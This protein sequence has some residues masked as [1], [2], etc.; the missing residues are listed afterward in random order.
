[1]TAVL[2]TNYLTPNALRET[3]PYIESFLGANPKRGIIY[4][5]KEDPVIGIVSESGVKI[6]ASMKRFLQSTPREGEKSQSK[7]N[8]E[9]SSKKE[10]KSEKSEKEEK[11]KQQQ[12]RLAAEKASANKKVR[13][14]GS[15]A[16]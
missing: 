15:C 4:P 13:E 11:E 10:K 7:W 16:V 6:D 3:I 14:G 12:D 8:Y 5:S 1:M 9:L 2:E